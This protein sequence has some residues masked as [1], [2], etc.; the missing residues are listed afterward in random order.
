[1]LLFTELHCAAQCRGSLDG[2]AVNRVLDGVSLID[3]ERSD[4]LRAGTSSWGLRNADALQLAVAL[5]VEAEEL[6]AYDQELV[7]ASERAGLAVARPES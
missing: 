6:V 2:A 3:L 4:L 1:M 5:R 7:A